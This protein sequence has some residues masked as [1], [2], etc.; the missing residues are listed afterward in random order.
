M[1]S[2]VG[3]EKPIWTCKDFLQSHLLLEELVFAPIAEAAVAKECER[4]E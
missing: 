3:E 4:P 2:A 1:K